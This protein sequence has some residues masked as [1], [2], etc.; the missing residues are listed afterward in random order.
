M[1]CALARRALAVLA[2]GTGLL[3]VA[4]AHVPA[5]DT[6]KPTV[7]HVGISSIGVGGKLFV[8]GQVIGSA[9]AKGLL[10]E[11]FKPDG[12]TIDWM[13]HKGAGPAVNEDIAAG[14]IDIAWQG[15]L[16]ALIG[17]SAGLRTHL[18]MAAN[19][20]G[21]T[22]L[23]VPTAS[24][25]RTLRDLIGKR[26]VIFKGTA[27]QLIVDRILQ[28]QGLSERD[29]QVIVLD[30]ASAITALT[31]GDVDAVWGNLVYFEL[32]DR[33]LVRFVF[34]TQDP[35]PPGTPAWATSQTVLLAADDFVTRY[36]AIVQRIVTLLVKEAAWAAD[37]AHSEQLYDL[38][39]R[40]G[41][42]ASHFREEYGAS[43]PLRRLSPLLDAEFLGNFAIGM[44]QAHDFHLIRAPIDLDAWIDRRFL[45]QALA[46]LQQPPPWIH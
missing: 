38:W 17:K 8:G 31:N 25:A 24:P 29:F 12:I 5:A 11:E 19:R 37:P 2:I 23:A 6:D 46:A 32:R 44:H 18:L 26:V 14:G 35:P 43:T 16:P 1:A 13:F 36:P 15:D 42:S 30:S 3:T 40:S 45:D 4:V 21:N 39:S 20:G 34:S 9:H 10:E 41:T 28:Q 7:I 33:G 22:Y 27:N